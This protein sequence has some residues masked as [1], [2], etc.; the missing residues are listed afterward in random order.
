MRTLVDPF[1]VMP[2]ALPALVDIDVDAT[3]FEA[4]SGIVAVTEPSAAPRAPA[5]PPSDSWT[6]LRCWCSEE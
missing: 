1:E 5:P 3:D 6:K 4:E 2:R